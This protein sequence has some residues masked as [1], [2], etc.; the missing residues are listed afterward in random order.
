MKRRLQSGL[1]SWINTPSGGIA[2]LKKNN[3]SM[4]D[5]YSPSNVQMTLLYLSF[6][7]QKIELVG[8]GSKPETFGHEEN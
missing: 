2:S 4:R 6:R 7:S 3:T 5:I 1:Y 8:N